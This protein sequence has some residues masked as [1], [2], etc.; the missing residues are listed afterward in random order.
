MRQLDDITAII[1]KAKKDVEEIKQRQLAGASNIVVYPQE[2]GNTWDYNAGVSLNAPRMILMY[3]VADDQYAPFV[4]FD[5]EI[6]LDDVPYDTTTDIRLNFIDFGLNSDALD[7]LNTLLSPEQQKRLAYQT[8]TFSGNPGTVN[9]KIKLRI[10]ATD[11]GT[12][13]IMVI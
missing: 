6:R 7:Q 13:G 3:F 8:Y 5:P 9:L 11:T 4:E 12:I 10:I 2:T 1:A